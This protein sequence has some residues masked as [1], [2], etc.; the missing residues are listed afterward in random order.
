MRVIKQGW[1]T[2]RPQRSHGLVSRDHE[3]FFVLTRDSLEWF[4]DARDITRVPHDRLLLHGLQIA[5]EGS[6]LRLL[7]PGERSP[8]VLVRG[9]LDEWQSA[10]VAQLRELAEEE[11]QSSGHVV[12]APMDQSVSAE[13]PAAAITGAASATV[14]SRASACERVAATLGHCHD[15]TSGVSLVE[16][17]TA[18]ADEDWSA[19]SWLASQGVANLIASSLLP[20]VRRDSSEELLRLRQLGETN[21]AELA[22]VLSRA[23]LVQRLADRLAPALRQL[24]QTEHATPGDLHQKFLQ[25]DAFEL[26][27]GGLHK[28]FA[29]LDAVVG[30]PS[31]RVEQEMKDE[32]TRR[33]DSS[34]RFGT[35]N[36][37]IE[38]TSQARPG[39]ARP[40]Y[41]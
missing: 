14:D 12:A 18:E 9:N 7:P 28:F 8:L 30:L 41:T 2:K 29:G 24:S 4:E 20:G 39:H 22:E 31:P 11:S 16:V 23:N 19:V 17:Q 25:G 27:F 38:T 1:L 37:G 15:P 26:E 6:Y 21:E 32:H 40:C 36:Y 5:R 3:R 35:G 13:A 33:A 34:Q 10:L